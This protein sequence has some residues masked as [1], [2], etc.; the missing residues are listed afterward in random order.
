VSVKRDLICGK[1]RGADLND[2]GMT[3]HRVGPVSAGSDERKMRSS[4][5][6]ARGNR[7][8]QDAARS[9][10]SKQ[11]ALSLIEGFNRCAPFKPF[12]RVI[13]SSLF[14]TSLWTDLSTPLEKK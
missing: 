3:L 11:P 7:Q 1:Q 13:R 8:Q 14:L 6:E 9:S 10:C 5:H 4:R 2:L 12:S